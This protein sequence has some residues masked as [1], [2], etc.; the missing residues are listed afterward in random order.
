MAVRTTITSL[1]GKSEV[2]VVSMAVQPCST[3]F[4]LP[5][6]PSHATARRRWFLIWNAAQVE[7]R[8]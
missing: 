3:P 7:E 5:P 8:S 2:E 4:A 6:L 1:T